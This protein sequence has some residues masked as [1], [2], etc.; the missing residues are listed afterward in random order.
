MSLYVIRLMRQFS[1][2]SSPVCSPDRF[3]QWSS[4]GWGCF[5][6]LLTFCL[7]FLQLVVQCYKRSSQGFEKGF[8][9]FNSLIILVSWEIWKQTARSADPVSVC[10]SLFSLTEH[11]WINRNQLKL[12]QPNKVVEWTET[13]HEKGE[14]LIT[15]PS[16]MTLS[17]CMVVIIRSSCSTSAP[18]TCPS[19]RRCSSKAEKWVRVPESRATSC[20]KL[21]STGGITCKVISFALQHI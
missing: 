19:V 2:S 14:R 8:E 10:F 3:G 15:T 7:S 13:M 11:Y 9:T 16:K 12:Y 21:R 6:L 17:L 18:K 5:L 4:N 20:S 1:T